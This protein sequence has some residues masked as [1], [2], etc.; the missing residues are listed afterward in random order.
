MEHDTY[1]TYKSR[2]WVL[3]TVALLTVSNNALWISFAAV[4]TA[5]AEYFDV[6]TSK[7]TWLTTISFLVGMPACLVSTYLIDRG[8][9]KLS[10]WITSMLTVAC[11]LIRFIVTLP[12]IRD[13]MSED[14]QF[15]FCMVAQTLIGIG[16]PICVSM[17]TK[18]S[19]NWFAESE[20][21][22]ATGILAMGLPIGITCGYGITAAFVQNGDDI[23]TMNVVWFIPAV[24][25]MGITMFAVRTS[26]PPTPPS[27]SA[28]ESLE[29]HQEPYWAK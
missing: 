10:V 29:S 28:A 4:T 5:T 20:I 15:I 1:V 27:R 8:G 26:M 18:V 25:T 6:T 19:Q 9:L 7:A 21:Q 12:G 11:G 2:W 17:P 3:G 24:I 23:P 16:N 22:L 13:S 14:L